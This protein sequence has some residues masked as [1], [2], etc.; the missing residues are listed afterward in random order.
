MVGKHPLSS[1]P[2]TFQWFLKICRILLSSSNLQL[3][4]FRYLSRYKCFHVLICGRFHTVSL[5]YLDKSFM[6]VRCLKSLP[7]LSWTFQFGVDFFWF[8]INRVTRV[9]NIPFLTKYIP[10]TYHIFFSIHILY[11]PFIK[12][13]I[14]LQIFNTVR[15]FSKPKWSSN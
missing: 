3:K 14:P 6:P 7:C 9:S 1:F 4:H 8:D 13:Y 2:S 10:D 12:R 5:P 11:K 15:K